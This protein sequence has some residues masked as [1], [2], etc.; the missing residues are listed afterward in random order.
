MGGPEAGVLWLKG[1]GVLPFYWEDTELTAEKLRDGWF[2]TGDL[3]FE[4]G[5]GYYHHVGRIDD[6]IKSAGWRISPVEIEEVLKQHPQV[7]DVAVVGIPD[8]RRGKAVVAVVVPSAS[9]I[10]KRDL[11][12]DLREMAYSQLAGYKVP[13]RF[14]FRET[15]P[16]T[17][18][19]KIQRKQLVDDIAARMESGEQD[20]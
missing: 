16:K 5:E 4:D 9:R 13:N 2:N 11:V 8:P 3:V 18:V 10:D 1:P 14:E 20:G 12:E 19:G 6:V 17:V 15:L 7:E